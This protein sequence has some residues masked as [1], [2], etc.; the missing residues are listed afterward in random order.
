LALFLT[1]EPDVPIALEPAEGRV[2][3]TELDRP[4]R[5]EQRVVG[6]LEV[7]TVSGLILEE[8]QHRMGDAHGRSYTTGVYTQSILVRRLSIMI[9]MMAA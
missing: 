3:L 4:T 1:R 9:V 7:V 8:A 2:D 6:L 5:G